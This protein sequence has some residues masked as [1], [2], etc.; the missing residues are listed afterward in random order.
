MVAAVRERLP[1]DVIE[2]AKQASV[3]E[4]T[5]LAGVV[6]RGGPREFEGACPKC[7]GTDRFHVHTDKGFFCR[8]CRPVEG[9][10]WGDAIAFVQWLEGLRFT[11]A[12]ERL[13]G[14]RLAELRTVRVNAPAAA[15]PVRKEFNAKRYED[16]LATAQRLLLSEPNGTPGRGYLVRRGL[17]SP[18]LWQTYGLGYLPL[19]PLPRVKDRKAP[20]IVLPWRSSS[21]QLVGLRYRFLEK[22]LYKSSADE[23]V[24]TKASSA[25]ASR[26]AGELFGLEGLPY[27]EETRAQ[28]ALVLCEGELNALSIASVGTTG[29]GWLR[30][31]ALSFGSGSTRLSAEAL[32]LARQY[33]RVFIWADRGEHA[34]A[35]RTQAEAEVQAFALSSP[36]DRES[37]REQDANDLLQ[38][39][40]LASYL[41]LAGEKAARSEYESEALLWD[42][43]DWAQERTLEA[44]AQRVFERLAQKLGKGLQAVHNVNRTAHT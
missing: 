20:A 35:L 22:Q 19:A 11:E 2:R 13:T 27:F 1:Q 39:G 38:H 12:V 15:Q 32:A 21:G 7:G 8:H 3:Y 30:F 26:I 4:L 43:W 10:G 5:Q 34:L 23:D 36:L 24:E 25:G 29:G 28:R 9:N 40:K 37:G 16:V 42:L 18:E 44:G 17:T 31:D 14:E 33:R 6:L 41:A